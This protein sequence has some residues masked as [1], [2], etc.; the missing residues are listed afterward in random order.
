MNKLIRFMQSY[1]IIGLPFVMG[2]V[3]WQSIQP[4]IEGIN[5]NHPLIKFM[6]QAL[7]I[8]IMVWFTVL[9]LFLLVLIVS[10]AVR[11]KTLRRLANLQERDEREQ[12]ITGKASRASYIA[13]LSMLLFFLFFSLFSV[14]VTKISPEQSI[15][16]HHYKTSLSVG[17]SLLN[18]DVN[19]TKSDEQT[20]FDS[21]N[22]SL[23]SSSIL[24]ILL[25]WQL[26]IFNYTARKEQNKIL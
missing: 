26:L 3:I 1:L 6:W 5:N 23:S 9:V 15:S 17:Y 11:E 13:T 4:G 16:G 14:T 8:N 7:G 19:E 10:S 22:I 2:I 20:I 21:K 25:C 12:Y 24:L 18:K